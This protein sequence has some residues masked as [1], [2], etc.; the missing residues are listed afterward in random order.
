LNSGD[1]DA[2]LNNKN[3]YLVDPWNII[4]TA[5]KIVKVIKNQELK[6]QLSQ[7]SLDFASHSDWDLVTKKYLNLYQKLKK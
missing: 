1:E 7:A 2:I 5:D 6:S 4:G 3:G